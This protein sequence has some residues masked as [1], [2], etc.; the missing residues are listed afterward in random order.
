MHLLESVRVGLEEKSK[1]QLALKLSKTVWVKTQTV[2]CLS[3]YERIKM[4]V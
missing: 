2:F 3:F 1:V 4:R